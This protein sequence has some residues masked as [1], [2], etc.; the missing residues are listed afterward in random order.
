MNKELFDAMKR[1]SVEELI[2]VLI[3]KDEYEKPAVNY[4]NDELARRNLN[5]TEIDAL[6]QMRRKI[7]EEIISK[8]TASLSIG[9]KLLY[10]LFPVIIPIYV[11]APFLIRH[12]LPHPPVLYTCGRAALTGKPHKLVG[13]LSWVCYFG[14]Q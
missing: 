11:V 5:Q 7:Y 13:I 6:F 4:A 9:W 8:S 10:I 3:R 12:L 2:D 1:Y 14:S